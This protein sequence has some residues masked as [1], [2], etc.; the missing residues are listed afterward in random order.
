[1]FFFIKDI[2]FLD[3]FATGVKKSRLH[4]LNLQ[5]SCRNNLNQNEYDVKLPLYI[6]G[7]AELARIQKNEPEVGTVYMWKEAGNERPVRETAASKGP[8]TRN[9]WLLWDQLILSIW[10]II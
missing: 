1:M 2:K 4:S 7:Y 5:S 8:F 10:H 6:T 9:L 3:F